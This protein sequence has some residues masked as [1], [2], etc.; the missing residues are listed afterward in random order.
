MY[1]VIHSEKAWQTF[2]TVIHLFENGFY[3]EITLFKNSFLTVITI[4]HNNSEAT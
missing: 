1:S 3:S 4:D 2:E